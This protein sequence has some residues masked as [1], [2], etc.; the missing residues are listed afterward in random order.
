[1]TRICWQRELI[2]VGRKAVWVLV[3]RIKRRKGQWNG[4]LKVGTVGSDAGD[5]PPGSDHARRAA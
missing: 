4:K 1:M 5:Y 3:G 2:F